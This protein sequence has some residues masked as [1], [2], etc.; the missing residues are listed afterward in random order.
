[1]P[2]D[3]EKARGKDETLFAIPLCDR[4]SQL[5]DLRA[6]SPTDVLVLLPE[7]VAV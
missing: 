3:D 2:V 6:P 1:M 4:S 7:V 5:F